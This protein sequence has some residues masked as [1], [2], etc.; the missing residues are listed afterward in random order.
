VEIAGTKISLLTTRGVLRRDL[1][2][3]GHLTAL[4]TTNAAGEQSPPLLIFP[5]ESTSA[6]PSD[7]FMRADVWTAF[8]P[9]AYMDK[10]IFCGGERMLIKSICSSSMG[11][12][13]V[14]ILTR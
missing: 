11:I 6:I 7:L 9:N 14:L 12:R 1:S 5:G 2:V 13:H 3:D 4:L 8:S 10:I